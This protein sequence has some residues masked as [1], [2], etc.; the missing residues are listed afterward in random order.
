MKKINRTY[1]LGALGLAIA[2]WIVWQA[3]Q[4]PMRLVANEPGPRFIPYVSAAGLALFS[5]LTII[6][7]APKEAKKGTKPYLDKA[8]WIR[9]AIIIGESI[10]FALSMVYIG[11]WITAMLGMML[12]IVTLKGKKKIHWVVAILLSIGLA[13]L[14]YFG[15]TRG[16]NIPLPK[17]E[18]WEALGIAMP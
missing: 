9:L 7:D 6:F 14:C 13:S 1:V 4:I 3:S 15:F 5:I 16:F 18:L 11:F 12:F 2:A 17:G 10:L 8:G